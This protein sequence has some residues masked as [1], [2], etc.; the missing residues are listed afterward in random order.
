MGR[1]RT[2]GAALTRAAGDLRDL[3]ELRKDAR[4]QSSPLPA[5]IQ[6]VELSW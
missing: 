2:A 3:L 6:Q 1:H 4:G 5:R